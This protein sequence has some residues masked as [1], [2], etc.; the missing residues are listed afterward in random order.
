[1][2]YD[3]IALGCGNQTKNELL[4]CWCTLWECV[5][6]ITF[7][8]CCLTKI[9]LHIHR[10]LVTVMLDLMIRTSSL[11]PPSIVAIGRDC[12]QDTRRF[13]TGVNCWLGLS[14]FAER[15][16]NKQAPQLVGQT[17]AL[18]CV[19][20]LG[21]TAASHTVAGPSSTALLCR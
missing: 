7:C 2:H 17:L 13:P 9:D 8:T 16:S 12:G 3:I 15:K 14:L 6:S 5:T 11:S 19:L 10:L 4:C 20:S 18:S 1:M 21:F